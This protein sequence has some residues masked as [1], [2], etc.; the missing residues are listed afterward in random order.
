V[1]GEFVKEV[2]FE[3]IS[4]DKLISIIKDGVEEQKKM[5]NFFDSLDITFTTKEEHPKK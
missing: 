5:N 2:K 3:G 1:L 4:D